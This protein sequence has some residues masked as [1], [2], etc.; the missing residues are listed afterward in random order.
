MAPGPLPVSIRIGDREYP[1][2]VVDFVHTG[3]S[4]VAYASN[5]AEAEVDPLHIAALLEA[6]ATSIRFHCAREERR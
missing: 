5:I 2:G 3:Q 1:I 6:V 4:P